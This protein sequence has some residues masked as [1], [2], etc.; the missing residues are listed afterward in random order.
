MT[1]RAARSGS[2]SYDDIDGAG[3]GRLVRHDRDFEVVDG[4]D[5]VFDDE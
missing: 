1:D 5:V 2:T 4:L 3:G